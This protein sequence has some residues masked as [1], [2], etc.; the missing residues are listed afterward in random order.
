MCV[1][2]L[3]QIKSARTHYAILA[4]WRESPRSASWTQPGVS[5]EK[6]RHAGWRALSVRPT[7]T[8]TAGAGTPGEDQA[9]GEDGVGH[10]TVRLLTRRGTRS[11]ASKFVP[12]L[13]R[14]PLLV[15]ACNLQNLGL[16]VTNTTLTPAGTL[17]LSLTCIWV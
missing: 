12:G 8:A 10:P 2:G 3:G 15:Y 6:G 14:T 1:H 16:F 13:S 17:S 11:Q 4:C 9:V 5:T 7:R